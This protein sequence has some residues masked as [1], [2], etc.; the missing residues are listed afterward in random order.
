MKG[1][2]KALYAYKSAVIIIKASS[3]DH[4]FAQ[5]AEVSRHFPHFSMKSSDKA[6]GAVSICVDYP[7]VDSEFISKIQSVVDGIRLCQW[8]VDAPPNV[9]NVNSYVSECHHVAARLSCGI[10]VI[11]GEELRDKGFGGLWGVGCASLELPALVILSHIPPQATPNAKSICMVGKGIVYDTGGLS[12]KV[13]NGMVGMKRDMGG[14]AAIL[15]AFEALVSSNASNSPLYAI[16]CIAENS[17]AAASTRPD[18][19]VSCVNCRR[20]LVS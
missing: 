19:I 6:K 13:G 3:Q 12:I 8:L 10:E 11:R 1:K 17:V 20:L 7:G 18:D 16:L 2:R 4:A 15:A 14:S 9:L 5:A